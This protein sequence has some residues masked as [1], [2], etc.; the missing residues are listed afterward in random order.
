F[1]GIVEASV[2]PVRVLDLEDLNK[3]DSLKDFQRNRFAH[4]L[5]VTALVN[6]G[7]TIATFLSL[8][9]ITAML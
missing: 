3:I 9:L 6:A 7:S 2:R 1:A 4:V 5:L 8:Y